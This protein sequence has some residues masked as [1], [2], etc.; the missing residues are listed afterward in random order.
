MSHTIR[1]KKKL[2][3]RVNRIRGQLN[4]IERALEGEQGCIEV[5]R[6]ITSCRGAM[7]GL[8]AVVLEDH[9]ESHLASVEHEGESGQADAKDVLIEVVH[10]YFK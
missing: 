3:A 4:A 9:I 10:S 2:L 1:D 5:L 6:Q 7:N 8:L